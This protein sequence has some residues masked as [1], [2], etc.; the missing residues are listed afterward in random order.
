VRVVCAC[1]RVRTSCSS[2][3]MSTSSRIWYAC[4]GQIHL[5]IRRQVVHEGRREEVLYTLSKLKM[6]S[7]SHTLPKYLSIALTSK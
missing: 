1:V 6:R 3:A 4:T 7:S 5:H 2:P